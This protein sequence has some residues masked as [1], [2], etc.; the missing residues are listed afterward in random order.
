[1]GAQPL[2]DFVFMTF[3]DLFLHLFQRKV[4]HVV[5]MQLLRCQNITKAQPQAV[6]KINFIGR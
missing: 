6:Q 1:M 2:Y 3:F 4:H 5:M